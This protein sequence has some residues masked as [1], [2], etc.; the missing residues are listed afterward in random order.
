MG[1]RRVQRGSDRCFQGEYSDALVSC[2]QS[3]TFPS[4]A[5]FVRTGL[6]PSPTRDRFIFV[7][8]QDFRRELVRKPDEHELSRDG[9]RALSHRGVLSINE[10]VPAARRLLARYRR[11]AK[12][13]PPCSSNSAAPS[14]FFA[15]PIEQPSFTCERAPIALK[16]LP[17]S[18]WVE[19]NCLNTSPIS[20]PGPM[21][22]ANVLGSIS[23][24]LKR[25]FIPSFELLIPT[26]RFQP[27]D[28]SFSSLMESAENWSVA[29]LMSS[30]ATAMNSARMPREE[31][32]QVPIAAPP[33]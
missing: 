33:T 18:F 9:L 16:L 15:F 26:A 32:V 28:C 17:P 25:I 20:S 7:S 8:V 11:Q 3:S 22:K 5:R 6:K 14:Y 30:R 12:A 29:K 1:L 4:E 24:C 21:I 13:V 19:A 31:N 10:H 2:G 23:I 27:S